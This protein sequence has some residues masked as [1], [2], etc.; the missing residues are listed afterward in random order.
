MQ[1][2][3]EQERAMNPI[4]GHKVKPV[5]KCGMMLKNILTKADPWMS[6]TCSR[7]DCIVCQ[8]EK[9]GN[10]KTRSIVYKNICLICRE[11]DNKTVYIGESH[12]SLYERSRNHW[13]DS[14]N[15]KK[16]EESHMAAHARGFHQG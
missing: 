1:A 8:G 14:V 4:L 10:C 2:I 11:Q 15:S 3:Q 7:E 13:D 16:Q 12:R 5:E 6:E 9:G